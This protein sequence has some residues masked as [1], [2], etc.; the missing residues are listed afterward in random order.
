MGSGGH[1]GSCESSWRRETEGD[2][3][4]R[5]LESWPPPVGTLS[6]EL[7]RRGQHLRAEGA[8]RS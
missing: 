6:F 5:R 2:G 1:Q 3:L 4:Y 7:H 8:S